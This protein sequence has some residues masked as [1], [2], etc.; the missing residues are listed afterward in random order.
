MPMWCLRDKQDLHLVDQ[1][2]WAPFCS[3]PSV[4]WHLGPYHSPGRPP[5]SSGSAPTFLL[6]IPHGWCPPSLY[7]FFHSFLTK[8]LSAKMHPLFYHPFKFPLFQALPISLEESQKLCFPFVLTMPC[9]ALS[10][11]CKQPP[12]YHLLFF[13]SSVPAECF[14][15]IFHRIASNI[16]KVHIRY[17]W[18]RNSNL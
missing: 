1:S 17:L 6:T 5:L 13:F 3:C 18:K 11:K 14:Y 12:L 15:C 16:L 2:P 4:C 10:P 9:Q 8:K 7:C